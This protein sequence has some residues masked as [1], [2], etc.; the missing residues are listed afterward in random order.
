M[1]SLDKSAASVVAFLTLVAL[2]LRLAVVVNSPF[3]LNDGGLFYSM[4]GDLIG[5][6]LALPEYSTY[7]AAGIPFAYPPFGLYFYAIVGLL[8][9]LP[10]LE[11]VKYGPP[12][13]SAASIPAFYLLAAAI[14]HSKPQAAF[15]TMAFAL[16]PRAFDWVIM[17]GGVTRAFGMLFALLAMWQAFLLFA[18]GSN[19]SLILLAVFGS[20]VVYSHPEAATHTALTA[21][22]F[23]LWFDRS[24]RGLL[25]AVVA[26]GAIAV[27]TAP[28]WAT[29]LSRF[30]I[31][32]FLA[33]AAAAKADGYNVLVG[34]FDLFRF[35]F[36]DE[37]FVTIFAGLGLLGIAVLLARREYLVPTWLLVMHVFEPR[38]GPL[39]MT[40]PLAM[41][42]GIALVAI[43]LPALRGT[44]DR[45]IRPADASDWLEASLN[46]RGAHLAVGFVMVYG[47]MS[48]YATG[49][50]IRQEFTLGAADQ[51]ALSWV[52]E[53]TA[54]TARFAIVTGELPLRD[55]TSEWFP[56]VTFRKS[57]ATVF[58]FEWIHIADFPSRIESYRMLQTCAQHDPACLQEWA[59][60]YDLQYDY[61]YLRAAGGADTVPLGALLDSSSE[62]Q[63][64]Y[65]TPTIKIYRL[66]VP[67]HAIEPEGGLEDGVHHNG[68][69]DKHEIQ[70]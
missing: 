68:G 32:P 37:P 41:C 38:G 44:Q 43:V 67:G 6:H 56:A 69:E 62:Y 20:L 52:K 27:L 7:N 24:R 30:G 48:A 58:G 29:V 34:L 5:N 60:E 10:V 22:L 39:F 23:Y 65:S 26:G 57:L 45:A 61:V 63:T 2:G 3:P 28:W 54:E 12:V 59:Q 35:D 8:L 11:L 1:K 47:M 17:G 46:G 51:A 13:L 66:K 64:V 33:A 36:A 53:N 49:W 31:S 15:G 4:I 40:I 14:T 9:R 50:R 19:R 42:A 70:A 25:K 55:A 18:A 16:V 21:I